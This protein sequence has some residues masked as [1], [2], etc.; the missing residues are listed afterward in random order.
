MWKSKNKNIL[1][2]AASLM[3]FFPA[4]ISLQA[5]TIAPSLFGINAWNF[6]NINNLN[7]LWA[8]VSASGVKYV[9]IGGI[10]A[11]FRPLY[12]FN[13]T[14]LAITNVSKLKQLIDSI[15]SHGMEPIVQVGYSPL[16]Q[17][18]DLTTNPLGGLSLVQQA[19]IAANL[20]DSL[21]NPSTGVYKNKPIKYWIIANE[22]DH[23]FDHSYP[24]GTNGNG[25]SG[26]YG[27]S[28]GTDA[29]TIADYIKK[30]ASKMKAKDDSLKIIGPETSWFQTPIMDSLTTPGGSSDITG[31][32]DNNSYYYI[33][34]YSFHIYP[35]SG[36][37]TRAQV[38]S[39]LTSTG[40]FQYNLGLLK[41]RLEACNNYHN[42]SGST[43]L[44][45]AVDEANI[46]SKN[47]SSNLVTGV[48]SNS[49]LAGQFWAEMM[50]ICM[51]EGADFLNFWSIKEGC[52]NA[53]TNNGYLEGCDGTP[54]STYH[55]FQMVANNFSGD[56]Y[57]GTITSLSTVKAFASR[58]IANSRISVFLMNQHETADYSYTIDFNGNTA[59][60]ISF[61]MGT[62]IT[63]YTGSTTLNH[64][65]SVLLVFDLAGNLQQKCVYAEGDAQPTCTSFSCNT[66]DAAG[67]IAGDS[68]IT[69]VQNGVSY[70]VSTIANAT[71][72][73][74]TLP[75]WAI[76]TSGGNTNSITVDYPSSAIS[77]NV[78]VRG[79]N[80]IC[81]GTSSSLA[82][83]VSCTP[84]AAPTATSNNSVCQ[85]DTIKLFSTSASNYAW[86][87][88]D[89]WTS[90][91]RNPI[92]TG[93]TID[94]AGTYTVTTSTGTCASQPGATLVEVAD[95]ASTT[96]GGTSTF[97]SGGNDTLFAATGTG[98][99]WQWIRNGTNISGATANKYGASTAGSYVV[100]ITK[101]SGTCSAWSSPVTI[102][103]N[104]TL[105]AKITA[106]GPT[107]FCS[108][109]SVVLYANTCSGYTYQWQAK[110]GNGVYQII[111][112]STSSTYTVTE[113]G[114]YQVRVSSGGNNQWSSGIEVIIDDT[115]SAAG[116]I[117]GS[118]TAAPGQSGVAYSVPLIS[119]ASSY[120]WNLPTGATI[121]T[122]ANTNNIIVNFSGSAVSGNITVV[123]T[124]GTC[125]GTSASKAITVTCTPPSTPT[126]T[127]NG[128]VCQSQTINL[129]STSASNYSWTG[130]GGWTSSV[131]N[132]TRTGA[133]IDMTG[134][135]SVTTASGGCTSSAG[136]TAV[137]VED[138]A[139]ITAERSLTFCSGDSVILHAET[140]TGYT[141]Q[142]KRNGTAITGATDHVYTAKT[143]GSYQVKIT[144][145]SGAC[146]AWSA[147]VTVTINSSLTA[148]ITPGGPTTFCPGGSVVLY[149]NTCSG[150]T[151]QWQKK[152]GNG[153]YQ[154]ISGATSSSYTVTTAGWYQ[155]KVTSGG[156]NQWSS[157]KEIVIST[158]PDAAGTISGAGTVIKGQNGVTYFVPVISGASGY[159]WTLPT[160]ASI[161]SGTNTNSVTVNFSTSAISGNITVEG[162]NGT[163]LGTS[164]SKAI[165]VNCS[166][167]ATPTATSNNSV[168]QSETI[169]LY[170]SSASNYSWTG[171]GGWTS[172]V[173]NPTR[174]GA[175]IAMTGTYSVTTTSSGCTS[176]AGTTVV[177][178]EDF[179][180]ITAGGP[181][182]FCS[183]G[184][185]ILY[186]E[187]GTGYTWQWKKNGTAI[188]GATASS[189]TAT[190]A[191]SYQVKISKNS[192]TCSAWSA[193]VTVTINSSLTATITPG[194]PTTFCPGGSVVLYANTCSGYTYQWQKKDTSGTY[195]F[196]SG[197]TSSSYTATTAGWYQVRVTSG[198]TNQ[199]SSGIEIIIGATPSAA[200]TITGSSIVIKGQNGVAYSVP[201]ISDANSYIWTVPTGATIAT[202]AYTNN[203][204]VDFSSSAVSGN[205]TV[206]GSNGT[207][208]GTSASKAITVNC[209]PPA[210]LTATCNGK[211]CQGDTITLF[212][213]SASNYLWTGPDG[214]TSTLQNPTRIGSTKAM[215]G[216]YTVT[217]T[218][219]GCTSL[220]G[221]T[222]V[223][224]ANFASITT[225]SCTTFCA[226]DNG[227]IALYASTGNDYTWQWIKDGADMVGETSY[228]L[229]VSATG[230]YQV[231]ITNGT[232][233]SWSDTTTVTVNSSLTAV[234]NT[235]GYPTSFCSGGYV[236][237]FA[238]KCGGYTCQWQQKDMS[239]VYQSMTGANNFFYVASESG[240]YRARVDSAGVNAYSTGIEV[241]ANPCKSL[242][243]G[244]VPTEETAQQYEPVVKKSIDVLSI[245]PNPTLGEFFVQIVIPEKTEAT[246]EV[247]NLL[248]QTIYKSEKIAANEGVLQ[249]RIIMNDENTPGLYIVKAIIGNRIL[250]SK[251]IFTK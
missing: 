75:A 78:T 60:A 203:I 25:P 247:I 126:A 74:W 157:G 94:M 242:I 38:I 7:P 40:G 148:A 137:M 251:F 29:A 104:S 202:G 160:G 6:S 28:S 201:A 119:G 236:T 16:C 127:S 227:A 142:W 17:I 44:K 207:C 238:N 163:C 69:P 62:G 146:S 185:V 95:F 123:G 150:Y 192:G 231:K 194:G 26:G 241:Q 222:F 77:G 244:N 169:N 177:T 56:Y 55:H 70:S 52:L 206:A 181:L 34:V 124:N 118:S 226:A 1:W 27:Y 162:T 158:A 190:T 199:Y 209:T 122:G 197:A 103:I 93:A 67:A 232:C 99:A 154:A 176:S 64:K 113:A 96:S 140:G 229:V 4:C 215:E 5:Q 168:C 65:S 125:S 214:W 152:D 37:Q 66:P 170:S 21:N 84:P 159:I 183:G 178:V 50:G 63:Q 135:Y 114:Y 115:P 22:P 86:S 80:G 39:K 97:C 213:T 13:T 205:V 172:S 76:I 71:S 8:D 109:G 91:I 47:P 10:G 208:S 79:T 138:F 165:T 33:D 54:R 31:L 144:K 219:G 171:P 143:A 211:V 191:G 240:W 82:I 216:N 59:N 106:G 15:R 187:T 155:V 224:V 107:T 73:I 186:A 145:N 11:N 83:V 149:A 196:I 90:T 173:Q 128:S 68:T 245:Y 9:R 89:G 132:P 108:G 204:T 235:S 193:T 130:P 24:C 228:E 248:G 42:R 166:P 51:K 237:L 116:T 210:M 117:S 110:D 217:T 156:S 98:Y 2:I 212:S 225:N 182:T 230:N 184:S 239:G 198:G 180:S 48:G 233:R 58:D 49:F 164:A 129:Y 23:D 88:P 92:R 36:A 179:A 141:W 200:G 188:T 153:T 87:G 32:I 112:G 3:L 35:F 134:T 53:P 30:F 243:I 195:Q 101:N 223:K 102:A 175:T 234:I 20:V 167:P 121:A 111:S 43:A 220:P 161:V 18:Y 61:A 19:T 105:T 221:I 189:Y 250:N 100:K 41:T 57:D 136:T 151:Y 246:F 120:I 72:Y 139:S 131:Q 12:S 147:T 218:S 14:S 46:N 174:S 85:N 133:T 249:K 81:S 45:M